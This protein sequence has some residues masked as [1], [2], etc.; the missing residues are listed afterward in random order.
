MYYCPLVPIPHLEELGCSRLA[1]VLCHLVGDGKNRYTEFHRQLSD[2]GAHVILD[3]GAYEAWLEQKPLLSLDEMLRRA[4]M[5]GAQEVQFPE[6]FWDGRETVSL[7]ASWIRD[8]GEDARQRYIWH[9]VVQ[10]GD[11]SDYEYCFDALAEMEG[12]DVIGLPKVV[13]PHCFAEACGT[14]ELAMSRIFA[15]TRLIRRTY[16][17]IHLL[18]L[19]DPREVLLQRRWGE[20]LRSADSSYPTIHAI[21]GILYSPAVTTYPVGLP[22][23]DFHSEIAPEV[24]GR[25]R[26]NLE[27]MRLWCGEP[28]EAYAFQ[29]SEATAVIVKQRTG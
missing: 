17:P 21:H 10:G 6:V 14:D 16:K 8:M 1:L 4:E 25:V 9:A 2:C 13:T 5:L 24:L 7:V 3:N 15:V 27:I 11:Q 23:F 19:E 26:H 18:G 12:V 20:Q 29:G 28:Q 22:R